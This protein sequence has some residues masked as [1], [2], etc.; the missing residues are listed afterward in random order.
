[1]AFST[2]SVVD[3]PIVLERSRLGQVY[4][5]LA[6]AMGLTVVGVF[7]GATVVL[8][9]MAS[10][11]FLVLLIAELAIVFTSRM[12]VQSYPLNYLLFAAFPLL[13]GLTLTPILMSILSGYVN[14]GTIVVNAAIATTLLT[15]G[16]AVFA[17]TTSVNLGFVGRFILSALIGL[18]AFGILQIIFPSLRGRDVE[19][20][21]SAVGVVLFALFI[22]YDIQRVQALARTEVSPFILALTLYL[23][24]YNLF[25]FI[26]RF[27]VAT[28]GRRR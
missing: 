3:A 23:D 1:M 4:G 10:G 28:S 16:M 20:L 12:W 15:V 24:I 14:G 26:L 2:P 11:F 8:P 19:M 21:F 6:L 27:V 13:S 18:I 25:I 7:L 5:L 9:L 22:A 17:S